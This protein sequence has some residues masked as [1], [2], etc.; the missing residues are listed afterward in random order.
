V[1]KADTAKIPMLAWGGD[2]TRGAHNRQG[3][4]RLPSTVAVLFNRVY[5]LG[6][7]SVTL[8]HI[9]AQGTEAAETDNS[10]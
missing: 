5:P 4:P 10:F 2:K 9:R 3:M 6:R 7:Q 1:K 8:R